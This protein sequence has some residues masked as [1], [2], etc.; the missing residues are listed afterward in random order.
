MSLTIRPL[1]P[2][3]EAEIIGR[4]LRASISEGDL[5]AVRR[6]LVAFGRRFGPLTALIRD[7]C[8]H[9]ETSEISIVSNAVEDGKGRTTPKPAG[10]YWH[11]DLSYDAD[12]ADALSPD[13]RRRRW[14]LFP[15]SSAITDW[16]SSAPRAPIGLLA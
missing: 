9:P 11:S 12:P 8:H 15:R 1:G 3:I 10:A 13:R 6:A 14:E 7:Q 4:D 5:R 16:R 2:G